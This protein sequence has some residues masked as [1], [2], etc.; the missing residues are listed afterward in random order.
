MKNFLSK[1][2]LTGMFIFVA[3]SLGAAEKAGESLWFEDYAQVRRLA[4]QKKR[5]I[6]MLFSGSDWCPPCIRLEKEVFQQK[7]FA[8][9]AASGKVILF[10]ADFPRTKKQNSK[11]A[12]QN[13]QLMQVYRVNGVPSVILTDPSGKEFARTGYR[14]G[15]AQ[16]YVEHLDKL[17]KKTK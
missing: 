13:R 4:A 11:I 10:W 8:D 1:L 17:L 14:P 3:C 2:C 7:P 16:A 12:A 6:L 5:P 9:F 15:G